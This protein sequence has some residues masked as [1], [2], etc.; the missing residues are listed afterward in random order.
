MLFSQRRVRSS[1][2]LLTTCL[3]TL[4][5]LCPQASAEPR[6]WP[7]FAQHQ[8]DVRAIALDP[9]TPPASASSSHD[10][11]SRN[12]LLNPGLIEFTDKEVWRVSAERTDLVFE[13]ADLGTDLAVNSEFKEILGGAVLPDGRLIVHHDSGALVYNRVSKRTQRL[14]GNTTFSIESGRVA[15]TSLKRIA[16]GANGHVFGLVVTRLQK[17]AEEESPFST[18]SDADCL[19]RVEIVEFQEQADGRWKSRR[20]AG[21]GREEFDPRHLGSLAKATPGLSMNLARCENS[22]LAVTAQGQFVIAHDFNLVIGKRPSPGNRFFLHP[23][24]QL[25]PSDSRSFRFAKT[26]VQTHDESFLVAGESGFNIGVLRVSLDGHHISALLHREE[27][28]DSFEIPNR[29]GVRGWPCDVAAHLLHFPR[30]RGALLLA[31]TPLGGF[32]MLQHRFEKSWMESLASYVQV[33]PKPP[34]ANAYQQLWFYDNDVYDRISPEFS[35]TLNA[36]AAGNTTPLNRTLSSWHT[37]INR[38]AADYVKSNP[39]TTPSLHPRTATE[40]NLWWAHGLK[41]ARDVLVRRT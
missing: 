35:Q 6:V 3:T 32:F 18:V 21:G 25:K 13:R 26:I 16:A 7:V 23:F 12:S 39:A 9:F 30:E 19:I 38:A 37:L 29:P 34:K 31:P 22:P 40:F 41:I 2:F 24:T 14:F 1:A 33:Y 17:T 10:T 28:P 20:V 36:Y 5:F 27:G 11:R 4:V 15:T 8:A